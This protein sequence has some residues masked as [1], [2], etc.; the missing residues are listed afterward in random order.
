MGGNGKDVL[1]GDEG[2]DI[3]GGEAGDDQIFGDGGNDNAVGGLGKDFINGGIGDDVLSGDDDDD[4]YSNYDELQES[5][6]ERNWIIG[7]KQFPRGHGWSVFAN[8]GRHGSEMLRGQA[9][10]RHRRSVR[11]G[12]LSRV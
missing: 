4:G 9:G 11:V 12:R 5:T 1:H 10:G 6:K 7:R 8:V 2:D 3:L